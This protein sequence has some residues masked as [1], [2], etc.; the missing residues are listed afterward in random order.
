MLNRIE[1]IVKIIAQ[2]ITIFGFIVGII[3]VCVAWRAH[4]ND[5]QQE[6]INKTFEL[7]HIYQSGE[8]LKARLE[9]DTLMTDLADTK[10]KSDKPLT[11][12]NL[13]EL[14]IKTLSKGQ[15]LNNYNFMMDFYDTVYKCIELE[16]CDRKTALSLFAEKA[17]DRLRVIF[18]VLVFRFQSD[19]THGLGLQCL[20]TRYDAKD[21]KK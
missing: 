16:A 9:L 13:I 2:I 1:Q 15:H 11:F 18:P 3:A 7:F 4:Q 12:P 17:N 20:A 10:D 5:I 19:P 6:K 8:V 14:M 21:C